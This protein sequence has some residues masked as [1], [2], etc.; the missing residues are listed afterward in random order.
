MN[1][2]Y[3]IAGVA[4]LL[5]AMTT[6]L[7]GFRV[8]PHVSYIPTTLALIIGLGGVGLFQPRQRRWAWLLLLVSLPLG[9]A[10]NL[11]SPYFPRA[12][13]FIAASLLFALFGALARPRKRAV[14]E[15]AREGA[16]EEKG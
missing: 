5:G 4:A 14:P 8:N 13:L 9:Y 2:L 12:S 15:E 1:I 16:R 3:G 7:I 11:T 6:W 10:V